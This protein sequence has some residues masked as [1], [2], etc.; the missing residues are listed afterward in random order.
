MS[1]RIEKLQIVTVFKKDPSIL[2]KMGPILAEIASRQN[3]EL[4]SINTPSN[5]SPETPRAV[6]KAKDF[7]LNICLNRFEAVIRP[8]KH[9]INDH[10]QSLEYARLRYEGVLTDLFKNEIDYQWTGF[11]VQIDIPKS[12]E[13]VSAIQTITPIFDS[14]INIDRKDK[15]LASFNLQFGFA[16]N[17]L[18]TNY[19]LTGYENRNIVLPNNI[20]PG[21]AVTVNVSKLP[22][23]EAGLQLMIDVNNRASASASK[24]NVK[25]DIK[26]LF[27]L[28]IKKF[29]DIETDL[30]VTI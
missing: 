27:E 5:A 3:G 30:K 11:V 7:L 18:N 29:N 26:T 16:E 22:V 24:Y 9:V 10:L 23:S 15:N 2:F 13:G 12:K 8:P 14:L 28:H 17:G 25:E 4:V 20:Q 19:I 1:Y 21:K 6:I